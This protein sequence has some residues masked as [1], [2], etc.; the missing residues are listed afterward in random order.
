MGARG[1]GGRR[2]SAPWGAHVI[3]RAR[4]SPRSG[5]PC[6]SFCSVLFTTTTARTACPSASE[7][8]LIAPRIVSPEESTSSMI[9]PFFPPPA[10]QF[11]DHPPRP[12]ADAVPVPAAGPPADLY[13]LRRRPPALQPAGEE[14]RDRLRREV[15]LVA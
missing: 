15:E 2:T 11:H 12:E 9:T 6:N 5:T 7:M 13:V 10:A 4:T 3:A 8:S 1:P 14:P